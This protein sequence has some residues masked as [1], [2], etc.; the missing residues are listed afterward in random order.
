MVHINSVSS[1]LSLEVVLEKISEITLQ[2]QQRQNLESLL[3][4]A[5]A[6]IRQ[7]LQADR[8][9]IYRFVMDQDAVVAFESVGTPWASLL[10]HSIYEP[11]FDA[12]WIEHHV[13]GRPSPIL[14]SQPEILDPVHV[15]QLERL[16][17]V[18]ARLAVP[19][20][21]QGRLWGLLI[22][23]HCR[24]PREW[25][26]LEIQ[27]LQHIALQL[28][29]A[30][31]LGT[32]GQPSP[33][34]PHGTLLGQEGLVTNPSDRSAAE[35][36]Q[37]ADLIQNIAQG[38]SAK[39][40]EA[41]FQ[42]LVHYLIRLLG[43]DYLLVGELIAPANDHV[44]IIA[45]L[46]HKQV[47][48]GLEYPLAG[49]PCE[50]VLEQGFCIYPDTVQQRFPG[51]LPLQTLG[52]EGYVGIPLMNSSEAVIGLIGAISNQPI[53]NV[54]F[55]Q[56]VLTIFAVR[57]ASELERQQSETMLR[58]YER[59]VSATPDGVSLV[60]CNYRY[61][62]INQT[63][64]T[65]NQKSYDQIVG[66]SIADLLGRE[67]FET[68]SKPH[69]DRCLAGEIGHSV[70]SWLDYADGQ[71][72]FTRA[73]Y[74]PYLETDGTI[75]GVVINVHDLTTLKLVEDALRESEERFQ[76][77]ANTIPQMFFVRSLNPDRY[78]Y[79]SPAY[80]K[81]WGRSLDE[82]RQNPQ[83]WQESIHPDDRSRVEA[84]LQLQFQGESVR[85]E[86]RIVRPDGAIR[87][88]SAVVSMIADDAGNPLRF[89]GLAADVSERKAAETALLEQQ[90]LTEQIAESTLAIMYIY[91]L[92]EQRNI[93]SN[94]QIAAVLGYDPDEIQSMGN[95]LFPSLIHPNDLAN[96]FANQRRLLNLQENEF[97]ET[98]YR[99]RHQDG[100]YRWLLSRDRVFS[101]TA[102]GI[103]KQSLGVATDITILKETQMALY[104][105]V[106]RQRLMMAIAQ[107][108]R[109]TLDLDHI[110]NTAVTEVR[111]FLQTDRVIIY[112]FEPD[113]SGFVI[114]ESVVEGWRSIL[115]MQVTDACFLA[116]QRHQYEQG[117][118]KAT[119]DI[120]TAGLD[121]CYIKLLEK[122][123]VRAK[124]VV[125]I[126]QD[127][128]LWGLLVAQHC[129]SPRCWDAL[130]IE[131]QQQLATQIAIAIQQA[132]LHQQVQTL[133]TGLELQ[134]QERT[135]Q[136]QQALDFEALL[137]RITDQ[138]RD[139]LDEAQILQK[140]VQELVLALKADCCDTAIYN[141]DRTATTVKYGY[142]RDG[143]TAPNSGRLIA[144]SSDANLYVPL[145]QG[146]Y[147]HFCL[148]E[149]NV[150]RPDQYRTV[151]LACPIIDDQGILGDMWLFKPSHDVFSDQEIRLVQ[152]VAT[153]CAI[154]LRQSHLY[155]A[156]QAQVKELEH[157]NQLKDDF[158]STVSHELRS[159]MS[160][161]KMATQMLEIS[162][163]RMG[164]LDDTSNAISRYFK[165]LREEGQREVNLINDLL[166]LARLDA[167]VEPL[168]LT[169]IELHLYIPPLVEVF[170]E[171]IR[172]QQQH[173]VFHIPTDLPPF[174]TDGSYL[175]RVLTELVHN[176]CKY[177]PTG[178]TITISA[179]FALET[180]KISVTNSGVEIPT[181]EC[182]RVF[183]KFY[184]IPN[185][186]PWKHGGTGLGLA[187]VKKLVERLGGDIHAESGGG[188]TRFI[189]TFQVAGFSAQERLKEQSSEPLR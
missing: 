83:I 30:V 39:T 55:I 172:Q 134:V 182:D 71:R 53:A 111:Q 165:I 29:T 97:M 38:V 108:I 68:V 23:H 140:A 136:V 156:A 180:L 187:L 152:Q 174:I 64:L 160:N 169:K 125:P 3:Q 110:L 60:D 61:Q 56:E 72:R 153:Q 43:M 123:Q 171:R 2:I 13:Q 20:P 48:N 98:E 128:R 96:V 77:I 163:T 15:H 106:E 178:D 40:G 10:G 16:L 137:K 104:Q 148:I 7:L 27:L 49:A 147:C 186:D 6:D 155:Q 18:Q 42:S 4:W 141:A 62:V 17:Q 109:Q 37:K 89:I 66:H 122:M 133:N 75:S 9:L 5:I 132:E 184:R 118:I 36:Q 168:N 177:T 162:L 28:G 116:T 85:R 92:I 175:S 166:D 113:W 52:A 21:H 79:I 142:N 93:Y 164:A 32:A 63:Y 76:E 46:S 8:V 107:R 78:V 88:I 70:E 179:E 170:S 1:L 151:V 74:T 143:Y 167:G 41:F 25:Q 112:R 95:T 158:L 22:A 129:Q 102:D 127:Q 31:Q 124:L 59:I 115:D 159:P 58:R 26:P 24:S 154:A 130:E 157:L 67:F 139:S 105:Q 173:L 33:P 51:N 181:A 120:Y 146:Q 117:K 12:A 47:L 34:P 135:A 69:F 176:A 84:S 14:T 45:G 149:Q 87:W 183:D 145:S 65:W 86:Y 99:M 82:L 44:K 54:Q 94:P 144:D 81:I 114:A 189:L 161:I 57:A 150:V 80:E 73:T 19:I 91:D 90:R 11:G 188:Q 121:P 100:N 119:D 103:P 131:L 101:Y 35:R 138:V 185:N 50:Q 126:V